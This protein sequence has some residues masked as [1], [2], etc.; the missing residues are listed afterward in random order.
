MLVQ[1]ARGIFMVA[2]LDKPRYPYANCLFIDDDRPAVIDLGAGANA[3]REIDCSRVQLV[4]LTHFH[5]DHVH[6]YDL[7]SHADLMAGQEEAAT[8]RDEQAYMEF[9]GY[10][11]WEELMKIPRQAYGQ[12]VP[13]KDDVLA[14]PGFRR[15]PLAGTLSDGQTIELGSIKL[16]A[17]HLPGHTRGHYGFYIEKE[18]ILFSGDIDLVATGPWYSSNS[19][20][21]G[22]LINS[23]QRIKEI[24]P[25][26]IIPS[27][28]HIQRENIAAQLDRYIGVVLERNQRLLEI[29]RN[30]HNLDQLAEY[31]LIFPNC[32][33]IYELFWEKMTLRNHLRYLIDQH[34]VQELPDGYYQRI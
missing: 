29:L 9:H 15:L 11:L 1:V 20:S 26:T 23:V 10:T 22:D 2:P 34:L 5:F 32:Q 33:N 25:D 14:R 13:L 27:H 12:V 16:T 18:G 6:G 30:P 24:N 19:A 21:V 28:R 8:Y 17:V 3:F 31:R 4:M 7:F